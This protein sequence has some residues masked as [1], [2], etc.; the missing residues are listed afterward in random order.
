MCGICGVIRFSESVDTE[1]STVERM[2]ETIV[3]RGP[4]DAGTY[5]SPDGS[6]AF[7]FRRLAIIDLSPDGHQP[8]ANEDGSVWIVFNGEIYNHEALR[9]EL[10]AKGHRYRSRTD[11]ETILHLYEEEG[12]RCVERLEG[13]F[14]LA[15]WDGNKRELFLARDRVGVKP[16]YYAEIPGG[17]VFGS[18]IKAILAHPA[19]RPDLDEKAFFD[20]LTFA[21]TPPPLT[22][23]KGIRKVAPAERML[24][25]ADGRIDRDEY[26]S[27]FSG[28]FQAEVRAMAPEEQVERLRELLRASIS[29]RMMSDVPYGVFLSGGLDSSLNVGLMSELTSE[30]VRTFS[31]APK[32]HAQYDELSYARIVAERFGTDHHEVR[33]DSDDMEAFLPT[34]LFHQDE[35]LADWTAIPQH[36]VTK[37]A[38]DNGVIVVQVGEGADELFHGYKGYR[39]HRRVVVPF[40]RWLSPRARRPIGDAALRFSRRTGRGIRHGE[41]LYD[42]SRSRLPYW[43]GALCFRGR[44]K[45]ELLVNGMAD[46]FEPS[47]ARVE[48]L[49]DRAEA[50][51]ADVDLFQ[52][53]TYVELKQ[54]LSELLLMRLDRITMA[55]SVEGREPFLDHDLVEFALALPP[56]QKWSGDHGKHILREAARGLLPDEVIDRKKQGFGTPMLEWLREDGF[57]RRAQETVRRSSLADRGL[58]DY[59]RVDE[60]F[61][62]HRNGAG[63]WSY[64]LWNLYSVSIWHDHWVAGQA[65]A[66]V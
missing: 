21:F 52:R 62:A 64:H 12:P 14:G 59:D 1:L 29:K 57:N 7:G 56:E 15:I 60:L 8:M 19:V 34:L 41:A 50:E 48:R 58:L 27:P 30:P 24:V 44:L 55:S 32:E 66:G 47:Y 26:W 54:R 49:W 18:E 5:R 42:A 9:A 13:M 11:S 39:D 46:R 63:D 3:H 31:T 16:L 2:A 4:D 25:R 28:S 22:M 20:Y 45:D 38:R 33:I 40:Q 37:L 10:E 51:L 53:M 61:A 23:Y 35:P 17:L 6:V 43:G 65:P 36:F